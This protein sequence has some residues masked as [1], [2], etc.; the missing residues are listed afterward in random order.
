MLL[1]W[2]FFL[3][4]SDKLA[5]FT[6]SCTDTYLTGAYDWTSVYVLSSQI[7]AN[8]LFNHKTAGMS[9]GI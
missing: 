9:E 1:N 5:Y 8:L 7:A 2:I 6:Q 4:A 3:P